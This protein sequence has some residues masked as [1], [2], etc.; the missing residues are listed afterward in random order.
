MSY[1]GPPRGTCAR[2]TFAPVFPPRA[3]TSPLAPLNLRNRRNL[4]TT[5]FATSAVLLVFRAI[6]NAGPLFAVSRCLCGGLLL[7][8]AP[9]ALVSAFLFSTP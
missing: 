7:A 3:A 4:R 9:C 8:F 6:A 5:L 1:C 2:V